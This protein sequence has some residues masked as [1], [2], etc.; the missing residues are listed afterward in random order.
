MPWR[1]ELQGLNRGIKMMLWTCNM[2]K[3]LLLFVASNTKGGSEMK[4]RNFGKEARLIW[5]GSYELIF[6][7]SLRILFKFK[8]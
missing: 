7:E 4:F 3:A 8:C 2:I 6:V 1:N 5:C